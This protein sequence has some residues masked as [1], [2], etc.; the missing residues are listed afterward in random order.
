MA[1]TDRVSLIREALQTLTPTELTIHDDS[2]SHI[3]HAGAKGGGHFQ[4]TI[5]SPL[6]QGK[7]AIQRHR[8]VYEALGSL[9]T[10]DIHAITITAKTPED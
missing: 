4:V 1:V 2:Q 3:G 10:T 6:F 5:I 7:M 8:M 9:M